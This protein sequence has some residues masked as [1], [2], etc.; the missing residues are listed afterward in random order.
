MATYFRWICAKINW[1][2][3]KLNTR[4]KLVNDR[5]QSCRIAGANGKFMNSSFAILI[6]QTNVSCSLKSQDSSVNVISLSLFTFILSSR[7]SS[8]FTQV[9]TLR[10]WKCYLIYAYSHQT[11]HMP[12]IHWIESA[13]EIIR[14]KLI[15]KSIF[16]LH[17]NSFRVWHRFSLGSTSFLPFMLK[18]STSDE[19][20]IRIES[21]LKGNRNARNSLTRWKFR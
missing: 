5:Y 11:Q 16:I 17:S 12:E 14:S 9:K 18:S 7:D 4:S 6:G 21:F 2:S 15:S 8:Q 20:I 13:H 19:W 1:F 3:L 10:G